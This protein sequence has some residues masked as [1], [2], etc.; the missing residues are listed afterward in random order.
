MAQFRHRT[1]R[2]FIESL[3][4]H[5]HKQPAELRYNTN[6]I[7]KAVLMDNGHHIAC[8]LAS[9]D[10]STDRGTVVYV[11]PYYCLDDINRD[12][13]EINSRLRMKKD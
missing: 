3:L 8:T 1:H 10:N 13:D 12:L 9:P 5:R 6:V 11:G 4:M 2:W 7:T